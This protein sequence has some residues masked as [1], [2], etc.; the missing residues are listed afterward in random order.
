[1]EEIFEGID[2]AYQ[3]NE[4]IVFYGHGI[5]DKPGKLNTSMDKLEAIIQYAYEKGMNFYTVLN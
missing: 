4:I 3:N 1:L 5:S 2:F